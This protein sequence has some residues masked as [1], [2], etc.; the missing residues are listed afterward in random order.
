[1]RETS[2]GH[3]RIAYLIVDDTRIVLLGVFHGRMEIERH[4]R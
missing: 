3:Y 1:M 4:L 2:Y